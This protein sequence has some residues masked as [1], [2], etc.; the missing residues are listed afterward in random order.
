ME[1]W[2]T[3]SRR[4]AAGP[5]G[6]AWYADNGRSADCRLC[7]DLDSIVGQTLKRLCLDGDGRN[8]AVWGD[9][10]CRRLLED[11]QAAKFGVDRKAKVGSAVR[12]CGWRL[13]GAVYFDKVLGQRLFMERKHTFLESHVRA[14]WREFH[15]SV[16]LS[17]TNRHR[18]AGLLQ[19]S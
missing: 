1:R 17:G 13:G 14:V 6:K 9:R 8:A 16:S 4:G 11:G 10:V 18:I 2:A 12:G 15:R 19:R 5:H 7:F 3:N